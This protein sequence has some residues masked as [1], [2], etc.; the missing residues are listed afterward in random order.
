[1][2]L[3]SEIFI[4]K[5]HY[6]KIG[7]KRVGLLAHPASVNK[8]LEHIA[9]ILQKKLKDRF[10]CAFGPQHGMRGDKQDNMIESDDFQDPKLQIPIYSLYGKHRRPTQESLDN[11]DVLLVDLQDIGTRLYTYV[12]TLYYMMEAL[13]GSGKEL[14]V[15]DR[16]NPAGRKVEGPILENYFTSF[17]GCHPGLIHRHGLTL[18]ELG[19]YFLAEKKFDLEYK[20]IK[21]QGYQANKTPGWGWPTNE[22]AWVNPSPNI[23]TLASCHTFAG[24]VL[25]EGTTL[26][27]GRGTTRPLELIG[28]PDIDATAVIKKMYSLSKKWSGGCILRPCYF[29]PTFHKHAKVL[30]SG[31][32]VHVDYKGYNANNFSAFRTVALTL[33]A[34][35][36]LYPDYDLWKKPPY[37]YELEKM[38]I[39]LIC[40][41]AK[42]REWVDDPAAKVSDLEGFLKP[43]E[44]AWKKSSKRFKLY[45]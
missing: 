42:L 24:T 7:K 28:A 25:I 22:Y 33:K 41:T 8:A 5:K 39:D 31:I 13:S 27:E 26:S 16:P 18:G 20:V 43:K 32:H 2:K 29:E 21:M 30:N 34:I 11:L 37:E 15:L 1:M 6:Q 3:G 4:E 23:P 35:R 38:P 17:V 19:N 12:T 9:D 14:W 36:S 44:E 40:G 10:T 45:V